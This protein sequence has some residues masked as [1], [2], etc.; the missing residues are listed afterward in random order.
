MPAPPDK[1]L[2]GIDTVR[3]GTLAKCRDSMKDETSLVT[4]AAETRTEG[5]EEVETRDVVIIRTTAVVVM[6]EAARERMTAVE[7]AEEAKAEAGATGTVLPAT[8]A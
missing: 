3:V 5:V 2:V 1:V 7:A 4:G 8:R 6:E